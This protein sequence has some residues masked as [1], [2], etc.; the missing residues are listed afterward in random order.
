MK[1]DISQDEWTYELEEIAETFKNDRENYVRAL[2]TFISYANDRYNTRLVGN[3]NVLMLFVVPNG[4]DVSRMYKPFAEMT[5]NDV[6]VYS[7]GTE[8]QTIKASEESNYTDVHI[9]ILN[10][11]EGKDAYNICL[12]SG[13]LY[14]RR[15]CNYIANINIYASTPID[16]REFKEVF[17]R[18]YDV[19]QLPSGD[20]LA[21][22]SYVIR[23]TSIPDILTVSSKNV[24]AHN[25][26]NSAKVNNVS[27]F[28]FIVHIMNGINED[29]GADKKVLLSGNRVVISDIRVNGGQSRNVDVWFV[30]CAS[31]RKLCMLLVAGIVIY[32]VGMICR[33]IG[34]R[35]VSAG[36]K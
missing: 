27:E 1:L 9:E 13:L 7:N 2:Q 5:G 31:Q 15:K 16:V 28:P 17:D 14:M 33:C 26:L 3:E 24:I 35:C 12:A 6:V 4:Y 22:E 8:V 25:I 32:V 34:C 19:I 18:H 21:D 29:I 36:Q 11:E 20:R 10:C 30:L 23:N